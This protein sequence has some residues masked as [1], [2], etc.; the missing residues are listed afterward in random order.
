[1]PADIRPQRGAQEKFLRCCADIVIYGGA[2]GGGKTYALLLEACRHIAN[3]GFAAVIFRQQ[4]PQIVNAGG[5]WAVS[6]E[7]YPSFLGRPFITPHRQ[8]RFPSGAK[9][10]FAHMFYEKEKLGWQGA[11][12]PL[13]MY[14]ELTHFSQSQFFYMLSRNRS[15]CGIRPYIRATCNPDADSWVANFIS[16][17]IDPETGYPI[18]ERSGVV[19]WFIRRN[20][21]ICWADSFRQIC[22]Q[23][24]LSTKQERLEPKSAT[25][26]ASTLYDNKI[27]M[28][29]DPLYLSNLKAL[30]Q[31]DREKLLYGNWKIRPSAGAFFRREQIRVA[32]DIPKGQVTQWAR[33][34]D[35]AATEPTQAN[36]SP[37]KTAG[38][39]MGKLKDGR[40]IV[41]DVKHAAL[42]A[43][44]VRSLLQN[45]AASDKATYGNV[46]IILPQ[47]PGQAGKDQAQ[48]LVKLLAGYN[49]KALPESGS[50]IARA[51]PFAAQWQAGN[52]LVVAGEWNEAFFAELESFPDGRH[53]DLVDAAAGAFGELSKK[54]ALKI[55]PALLNTRWR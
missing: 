3:P 41:A 33:R 6:H 5:L 22:E 31:V 18:K 19:R 50:K 4:A 25:F 43:A 30:S 1:M 40:F 10:T 13:I 37:D 26:I 34:W 7:I 29:K 9:I 53:D 49:V 44:S 21:A 42:N 48:T 12:I 15:T 27:L 32:P 55:S 36:P 16:W 11:Q 23:F 39:L 45:T 35:L 28:E 14:D 52:V 46:R 24:S 17:W 8:W 20:D 47:D 2:A 54:S 51:E 38:V